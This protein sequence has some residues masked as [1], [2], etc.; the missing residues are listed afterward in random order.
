M[1]SMLS[2]LALAWIST[3]AALVLLYYLIAKVGPIFTATANY[4]VPLTGLFLGV[5]LLKE[6]LPSLTMPAIALILTG[7]WLVKSSRRPG[8]VSQ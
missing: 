6:T 8:M 7:L 3:A 2:G 5:V 1:M 4:L